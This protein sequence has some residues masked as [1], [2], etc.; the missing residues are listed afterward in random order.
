MK[1]YSKTI[2]FLI[3]I[4]FILGVVFYVVYKK[5]SFSS[6]Y[7]NVPK[8]NVYKKINIDDALDLIENKTGIIYIGYPTCPWCKSLVPILNEVAKEDEVNTIYY[9]DDFYSMRPDKN[10]KPKNVKEY[11]KLVD[12]LGREIVDMKSENSQFNVIKV[13]LVLFI[14]DGKIVDYHKGTYQGHTLKEKVDK[15]G[16]TIKY[17]EELTE[18][19]KNQIKNTLDKKIRKVYSNKCDDTGC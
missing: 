10:E 8:D 3:F 6:L 13:P 16:N 15:D 17:L 18:K 7:S 14:K 11:N 1:R 2:I 19:Q 4:L 5:N 9:I 12:L